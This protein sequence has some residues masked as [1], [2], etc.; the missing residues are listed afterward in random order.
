MLLHPLVVSVSRNVWTV[1]CL[2]PTCSAGLQ[3]FS[4][5]SV[6]LGGLSW[7]EVS[8][9][10]I[11]FLKNTWICL[12]V[13]GVVHVSAGAREKIRRPWIWIPEAGVTDC[14]NSRMQVLGPDSRSQEEQ[15]ASS[16]AELS[17]WGHQYPFLRTVF[18]VLLKRLHSMSTLGVEEPWASLRHRVCSYLSWKRS[19][20]LPTNQGVNIGS[21]EKE[22]ATK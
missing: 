21:N 3:W 14:C 7:G 11:F 16:M 5:A 10:F 13:G 22:K 19:V 1:L 4:W 17:L 2:R 12:W 6:C 18:F 20:H 8:T 15:Q 9:K